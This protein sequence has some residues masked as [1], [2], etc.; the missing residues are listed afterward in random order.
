RDLLNAFRSGFV[1]VKSTTPELL[2]VLADSNAGDVVRLTVART[3]VE[4]DDPETVRPLFE[5]SESSGSQFKMLIEPALARWDYRPIREIWRARLDNEKTFHRELLLACRGSG[6]TQ[7]AAALAGLLKLVHSPER[8]RDVRLAAARAA[9]QIAEKQL[10]PEA[11]RLLAPSNPA[12]IDRLCAVSLLQRHDSPEAR[13]LLRQLFADSNGS[14]AHPAIGRLYEIDPALVLELFERASVH[15]DAAVRRVAARSYITL[16]AVE[17]LSGLA[18]LLD[19]PDP[20]LRRE[21]R[22]ALLRFSQQAEFAAPVRELSMQI[23]HADGWRGQEQAALILGKLDYDPAADRLV[24]LLASNRSEVVITSAWGLKQ[25]AVPATLPAMLARATLQNESPQSD[26][27]VAVDRQMAHLFEAM[28]QMDYKP[29]IPLA[30]KMVPKVLDHRRLSRAAACWSLGYLMDGLSDEQFETELF[31][32]AADD[33]SLMPEIEIVRWMCAISLGRLKA[34]SQLD[35][36]I[37]KIGPT[38]EDSPPE[39]AM[40]WSIRLLGGKDVPL[41]EPPPDY[42]L[43][44]WLIQPLNSNP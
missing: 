19:D 24:E 17:R 38:V 18:R 42:V 22:D 28:G 15:S 41:R 39:H 3:L 25:L 27:L 6:I 14:V 12:S 8:P 44:E 33:M 10:E 13:E 5:L 32:R 37:K 4:F 23:L 29:A 9:A 2:A 36:L 20:P 31:D 26:D 34:K 35:A 43:R 21:V 1:E 30:R 40:L 7:D 11:K 16:P